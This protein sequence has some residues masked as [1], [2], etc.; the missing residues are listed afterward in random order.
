MKLPAGKD[1]GKPIFGMDFAMKA[2][3]WGLMLAKFFGKRSYGLDESVMITAYSYRGK[4]YLTDS[5]I[6]ENKK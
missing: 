4:L 3:C 6:M 1:P 2:S 5:K